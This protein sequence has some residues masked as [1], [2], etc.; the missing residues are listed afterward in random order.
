M[1]ELIEYKCLECG[2]Y[3]ISRNDGARCEKC[4]GALQPIRRVT[5]GKAGL[6]VEVS[7]KDTKLFEEMI[8]IFSD[9]IN[10]PDTPKRIK[11]KIQELILKEI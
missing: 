4:N 10:D 11:E 8:M 2:Q 1:N 6:K 9:L 5:K 7:I 3:T